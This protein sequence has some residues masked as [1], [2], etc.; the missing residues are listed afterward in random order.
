MIKP[1]NLL[2][3]LSCSILFILHKRFQPSHFALLLLILCPFDNN[4]QQTTTTTI[5]E[6]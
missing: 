5:L 2:P 3:H 4:K 1:V 6:Q